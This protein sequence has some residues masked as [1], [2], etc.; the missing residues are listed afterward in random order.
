MKKLW[1]V[2]VMTFLLL[3]TL[4]IE[5]F[6]INKDPIINGSQEYNALP[7]QFS[8]RDIDGVDFTT[9]KIDFPVVRPLPLLPLLK[10][11]FNTK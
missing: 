4:S 2:L 11:W 7:S 6:Q 9:I 3:S 10:P 1:I 5:G 8:W